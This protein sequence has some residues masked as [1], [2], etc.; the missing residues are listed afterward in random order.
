MAVRVLALF[1][2]FCFAQDA[3]A[4]RCYFAGWPSTENNQGKCRPPW[5]GVPDVTGAKK[6]FTCADGRVRCH[7]TYYG[8][9]ICI[10]KPGDIH[11][12]DTNL[13]CLKNSPSTVNRYRSDEAFRR[14]S[15][16][17]LGAAY[18]RYCQGRSSNL[19]CSGDDPN[20]GLNACQTSSRPRESALENL[21]GTMGRIAA[22]AGIIG[23]AGLVLSRGSGQNSSPDPDGQM[24][25]RYGTNEG[26]GSAPESSAPETMRDLP[27]GRRTATGGASSL[28]RR[29]STEPV[30]GQEFLDRL[31]E[32]PQNC[33]YAFNNWNSDKLRQ[34]DQ[35]I[36]SAQRDGAIPCHPSDC[37]TASYLAL[38]E[39]LQGTPHA[40]NLDFR[41]GRDLYRRFVMEV[42][43]IER[44]FGP[45]PT[46]LGLGDFRKIPSNQ[47]DSHLQTGWPAPGDFVLL[48]R[49]NRSGH[50]T[51]FSHFEGEGSNRRI[52]YWSSNRGTNGMGMQCERM[53]TIGSIHAGRVQQ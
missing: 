37:A 53:S 35:A 32:Y 23:A 51:V 30:G 15:L 27:E 1:L 12:A 44:T 40:Q 47:L 28:P 25:G 14:H 33:G 29:S 10:G 2:F 41:R 48:N 20:I 38:I 19:N 43:S 42:N 39:R 3:W 13:E 34:L 4:T 36:E 24:Q 52:C 50:M 22:V 6:R 7:P 21:G 49:N 26:S 18:G 31:R 5:F 8:P 11:F 16:P 17:V 45:S 9:N 46:G